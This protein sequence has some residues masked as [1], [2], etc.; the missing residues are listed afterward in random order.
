MEIGGLLH[1]GVQTR[2]NGFLFLFTVFDKHVIRLI[3][4]THVSRSNLSRFIVFV[5]YW[6]KN[7]EKKTGNI[8]IE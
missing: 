2:M 5:C 6:N 4:M 1:L 7:K 8:Q 3:K